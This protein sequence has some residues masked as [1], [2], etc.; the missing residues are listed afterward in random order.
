MVGGRIMSSMTPLKFVNRNGQAVKGVVVTPE[1]TAASSTG[2]VYLPGIVLG[3]VAVHRLGLK[4]ADRL[5]AQGHSTI[6]FDQAGIGESEGD[7]PT[8]SHLEL[9]GWVEGGAL[10][11]DTLSAIDLFMAKTGVTQVGVLGHCGGALTAMYTAAKHPAVK[12]VFLISPPTYRMGAVPELEKQNVVD[13]YFG[14]YLRRLVT[15]ESWKRLL[16]GKS[17]YATLVKVLRKRIGRKL[18]ALRGAP[19]PASPAAAASSPAAESP[20]NEALIES[21]NKVLGAGVQLTIVFGDRDPNLA[22]FHE[23]RAK[24][25]PPSVPATIFEA[26]SHG[27]VTEE[28]LRLL[29]EAVDQFANGLVPQMPLAAS[30]ER[31]A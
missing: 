14:L 4:V 30:Q 10:V 11:A 17:D 7:H 20:F 26:T 3:S 27:F 18:A 28:S 1:D 31:V 22:E 12:G 25:L 9:C 2:F 15:L 29:F 21:L 16:A 5:A 23:F 19:E 24:F 13:E 8:G 6:L